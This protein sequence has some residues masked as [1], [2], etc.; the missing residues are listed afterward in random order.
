MPVPMTD[1]RNYRELSESEQQ[2][3]WKA[4]RAGKKEASE[5]LI[6]YNYPLVQAVASRFAFD[7]Q[8]REDL[9]Q[10]GLLGLLHAMERFDPKREVPFG[11]FAFPY[12]KDEVLKSL[13]ETKG[14]TKYALQKIRTDIPMKTA[15][16]NTPFSLEE[17]LEN[18]ESTA[19]AD[20]NAEAM[21]RAVENRMALRSAAKQLRKEERQ[22]LY[23]R[24][25]LR[26]SQTETGKILSLSQT[27]I[28]RKEQEI[29]AKLREMI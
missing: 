12:I 4:F 21:F 17:W 2:D 22:L 28:S 27:R 11:T 5:K 7:R 1:H 10:G 19:L 14:R 9:V 15:A 18:G 13:A 29:L 26:K 16:E 6:A 20:K 3:L 25:V 8:R 23:C 24:Y